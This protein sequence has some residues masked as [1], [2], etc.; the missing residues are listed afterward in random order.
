MAATASFYLMPV[1][2]EPPLFRCPL[3]PWLP[4]LGMLCCL[5]LIGSLGWPAYVRWVV[6]F[7]IGV[8]VYLCYGLH[9]S[10]V[11]ERM[12]ARALCLYVCRVLHACMHAFMVHWQPTGR[13]CGM[14][15]S[16]LLACVCWR[17]LARANVCT[18][19]CRAG[20]MQ[21]HAAAL[22]TIHVLAFLVLKAARWCCP[23]A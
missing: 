10:Q 1:R 7:S 9:N 13:P 23:W 21:G 8:A 2:Y 17:V 5:H 4:S 6:W 12:H 19:G 16:C 11:R 18:G 14:R 20:R 15:A 3:V 22:P